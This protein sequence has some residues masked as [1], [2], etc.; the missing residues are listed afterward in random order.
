MVLNILAMVLKS[1]GFGVKLSI[2]EVSIAYILEMVVSG[3]IVKLAI[4]GVNCGWL[5]RVILL[6]ANIICMVLKSAIFI[7]GIVFYVDWVYVVVGHNS[8]SNDE[9]LGVYWTVFV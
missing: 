9:A 1:K 4:E 3:F 5:N 7:C 6:E 2:G 8:S